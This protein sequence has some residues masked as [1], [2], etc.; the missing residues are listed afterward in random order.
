M[1]EVDQGISNRGFR[2]C[3]KRSPCLPTGRFEGTNVSTVTQINQL[4]RNADRKRGVG[5]LWSNTEWK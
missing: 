2:R 1:V 4:R 3:E 5:E